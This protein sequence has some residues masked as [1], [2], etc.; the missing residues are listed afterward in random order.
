LTGGAPS[1]MLRPV[2]LV[3]T[4]LGAIVV[5]GL[6][7]CAQSIATGAADRPLTPT[8]K[9]QLLRA[10]EVRR[11][12]LDASRCAQSS[13]AAQLEARAPYYNGA[14]AFE[15]KGCGPGP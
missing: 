2:K 10:E 9:E 11:N 5:G 6:A 13:P 12:H 1:R 14:G 4:L 15:A 3:S 7:G 8:E